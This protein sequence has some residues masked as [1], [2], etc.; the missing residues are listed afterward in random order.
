MSGT[1]VLLGDG[2]I[3]QQVV[4]LGGVSGSGVFTPAAN[5]H[6]AG[7]V[8]GAAQEFALG[9]PSGCLFLITD[10]DLLINSGAAEATA[11]RLHLY[12]ITPPSALADDTPFDVPA[13]DQA[14][15]LGF[16]DIG[17]AVDQGADT[18]WIQNSQVN[19]TVKLAGTSVFGYLVNLATIT[20]AAVAHTVRLRGTPI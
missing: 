5:S 16:I 9:A 15:Y 8:N 7:D 18:L 14:S 10:V 11:W 12:S 2:T 20:P 6:A 19:R 4:Q 13:G 1:R 3:A 17:T